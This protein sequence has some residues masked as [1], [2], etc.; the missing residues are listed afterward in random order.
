[1]AKESPTKQKTEIIE[2][3][4]KGKVLGRL[5]T[6][7]AVLLM[8]KNRPDFAPYK[9]FEQ[10]IKITN[11]KRVK[12]TGKKADRKMYWRHSGYPGGIKGR[13][14]AEQRDIDAT[15]IIRAAVA[16]MLPKNRLQSRRLNRLTI[17]E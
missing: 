17:E 12:V 14:F 8:G 5:A 13:T 15:Q 6:D 4:A 7:V 11:A 10:T 3:D 2:I 16:G 9:D 1:M